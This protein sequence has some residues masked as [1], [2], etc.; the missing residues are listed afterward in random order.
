MLNIGKGEKDK[1]PMSIEASCPATIEIP[2]E[3]WR[4]FCQ[5]LGLH[6]GALVDVEVH[7]AS[8]ERQL[9]RDVPFR[10]V[11]FDD[12]GEPDLVFV[13]YGLPSR[14]PLQHRVVAPVHF[15]LRRHG[16]DPGYGRLEI[17]GQCGM[18][19]VNF[20]PGIHP[21]LLEGLT[22]AHPIAAGLAPLALVNQA[23]RSYF[24]A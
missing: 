17:P 3:G 7:F 1:R 22:P 8:S 13:E 4:L 21:A 23:G 2:R 5:R 12:F 19:V 20:R 24:P 10:A 18:T 14:A 16:E 9:A 15:V 6:R 11:V